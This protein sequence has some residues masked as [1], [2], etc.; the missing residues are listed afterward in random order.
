MERETARRSA[1]VM[2]REMAGRSVQER[3]LEM[4]QG[5]AM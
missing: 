4:V 2:E 3:V 5:K 1:P